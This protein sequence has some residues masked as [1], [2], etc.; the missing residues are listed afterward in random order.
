[1][2]TLPPQHPETSF[3]QRLQSAIYMCETTAHTFLH[4]ASIH[5]LSIDQ[6]KSTYY[7]WQ[8]T[9]HDRRVLQENEI[10]VPKLPRGRPSIRAIEEEQVI[11]DCIS[12]YIDN[13]TPLTIHGLRNL[14]K[15]FI[16]KLPLGIKIEI[17]FKNK[18]P[19]KHWVIGYL[20]RHPDSQMKTVR[21]IENKRITA[22]TRENVSTRIARV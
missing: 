6:L 14:V 12:Y 13:C 4:I 7:R 21:A 1:M 17:K 9:Q 18:L 20:K 5:Q 10:T 22:V 19:S 15:E 16:S 11:H 2:S 3:E 8:R